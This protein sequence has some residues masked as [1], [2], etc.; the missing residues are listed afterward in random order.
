MQFFID[1]L[2]KRNFGLYILRVVIQWCKLCK[3]EDQILFVDQSMATI[4]T[5]CFKVIL[6]E[7]TLNILKSE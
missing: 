1:L 5:E 3:T 7:I 2:I 6:G 4:L